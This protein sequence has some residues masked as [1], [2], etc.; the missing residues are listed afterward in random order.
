MGVVWFK[1]LKG[2]PSGKPTWQKWL[3]I[4]LNFIIITLGWILFRSESISQAWLI[5]KSLFSIYLSVADFMERLYSIDYLL[6]RGFLLL[7]ITVEIFCE[8][9]GKKFNFAL[10]PWY[11]RWLVYLFLIIC[12]TTLGMYPQGG[13]PFVYFRF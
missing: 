13:N 4:A 7:V 3:Y 9:R 6:S 8:I 11:I 5:F 1:S 2:I 12:I 10:S